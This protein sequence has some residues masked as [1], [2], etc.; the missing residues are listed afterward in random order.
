MQSLSKLP[1]ETILLDCR[2]AKRSSGSRFAK[3]T[4]AKRDWIKGE[5]EVWFLRE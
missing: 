4:G 3:R 2:G 1:A 5:K